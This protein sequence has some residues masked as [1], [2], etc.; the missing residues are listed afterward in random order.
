MKDHFLCS[1]GNRKNFIGKG[2]VTMNE[3]MFKKLKAAKSA[4]EM[5]A[6]AREYGKELTKEQ[7]EEML[8]LAN[9]GNELSDDELDEVAGGINV[10]DWVKKYG[11]EVLKLMK[12]LF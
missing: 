3:E 6:V 7:A 5:I 4:E 10:P 12:Y 11:P 2:D 9:E 8:T 1:T